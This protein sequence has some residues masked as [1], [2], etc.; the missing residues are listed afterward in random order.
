M[1]TGVW[2]G[3]GGKVLERWLSSLWPGVTFWGS[4]VLLVL[5]DAHGLRGIDR[6]VRRWAAGTGLVAPL[7]ASVLL[8]LV[9][10]SS[11][12]LVQQ[13]TRPVLM[14]L[15]GQSPGR[16]S[17]VRR[18]LIDRRARR[19]DREHAQ[20][21]TLV[22]VPEQH[23]SADQLGQLR[24]LE[25]R[26]VRRPQQRSALTPTRT[27]DLLSAA[28]RY[29]AD[30]YGLD[31]AATWP[32]L[33]A[34]LPETTRA[35]LAAARRNLDLAVSAAVWG[36]AFCLLGFVTAWAVLIGSVVVVVSVLW[37][38][39]AHADVFRELVA[40]AFDCHRRELYRALRWPLP[41]NPA[42]ELTTGAEL[43]RYLWRGSDDNHPVFEA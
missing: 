30:R 35:E 39:P 2:A 25:V 12:V 40:V 19:V 14:V 21:Q 33:W 10:A 32:V 26:R 17:A 22:S 1:L 31:A 7:V 29:P 11:A 8:L 3:A 9:S 13:A 23:R 43:S 28:E 16:P 5:W 4:A 34:V 18:R 24:R 36:A 42:E 38:V 20:W 27:G 6:E 37:L 41:K 15:A